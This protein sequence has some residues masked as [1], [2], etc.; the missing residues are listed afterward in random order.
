M[1]LKIKKQLPTGGDAEYW[2][3]KS[4]VNDTDSGCTVYMLGYVNQT[5]R[6]GNRT[7]AEQMSL[8]VDIDIKTYDKKLIEE[9]YKKV[10][11]DKFFE[12][13]QDV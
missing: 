5:A 3:I 9:A 12:G 13:A 11:T 1:A 4:I 10:K 7:P 2:R 8:S 6:E